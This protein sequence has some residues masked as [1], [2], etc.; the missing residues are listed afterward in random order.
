LIAGACKKEAADVA[1]PDLN[2]IPKPMQVTAKEGTFQLANGFLAAPK[3]LQNEANIFS[4]MIHSQT[5]ITLVQKYPE[6]A[7]VHLTLDKNIANAE[8]Y[9]IKITPE[10]I[11]LT[12][13]TPA[14]VFYA[15]QTFRQILPGEKSSV[16]L[17]PH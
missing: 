1:V 8:G 11:S 12:G 14:A 6:E 9:Q 5:G 13:K 2:V 17:A 3:E 15:I 7:T 16:S 4:A 10:L